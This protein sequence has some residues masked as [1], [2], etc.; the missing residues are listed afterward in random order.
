MSMQPSSFPF[1]SFPRLCPRPFT[2]RFTLTR[3]HKHTHILTRR[4][5]TMRTHPVCTLIGVEGGIFNVATGC[6]RCCDRCILH[7]LKTRQQQQQ[8]RRG[9]SAPRLLDNAVPVPK[10]V[11]GVN[12]SY[13]TLGSPPRTFQ[14]PLLPAAP[15]LSRP[16]S[17]SLNLSLNLSLD[18]SL[19]LSPLSQPLSTSLSIP[20]NLS[21]N[22]S[23][24]L[25]SLSLPLNL[26]LP[27]PDHSLASLV[28]SS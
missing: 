8:R 26:S 4:H 19:S 25:F 15:D 9:E 1:L 3:T 12:Y 11:G 24:S 23:T 5:T 27:P 21:L 28:W 22:L 18:L 10:L 13:L 16:L 6:V 20:L 17:L 14:K 2:F 7:K